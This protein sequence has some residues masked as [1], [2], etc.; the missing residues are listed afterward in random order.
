MSGVGVGGTVGRA[1]STAAVT[2]AGMSGVGVA[3]VV[4]HPTNPKMLN[5]NRNATDF[6]L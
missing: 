1:A 5:R 4:M 6:M 2:V 3:T